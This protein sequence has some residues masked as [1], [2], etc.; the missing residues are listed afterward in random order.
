[1]GTSPKMS[2]FLLACVLSIIDFFYIIVIFLSLI[3]M[4]TISMIHQVVLLFDFLN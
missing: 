2:D 1:M 4:A 3:K